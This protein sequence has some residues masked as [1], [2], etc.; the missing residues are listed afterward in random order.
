MHPRRW[1]N[2]KLIWIAASELTITIDYGLFWL[3]I[4]IYRGF[5]LFHISFLT[6]FMICS[7]SWGTCFKGTKS[8][9]LMGTSVRNGKKLFILF[10]KKYYFIRTL[11][12]SYYNNLFRRVNN[13]TV[14]ETP[15]LKNYFHSWRKY[16]QARRFIENQVFTISVLLPCFGVF[17][18]FKLMQLVCLVMQWCSLKCSR[19]KINIWSSRG[20]LLLP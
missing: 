5:F 20:L 13:G 6:G 17:S 15:M 9:S 10:G 14:F 7:I 8:M 18:L 1:H 4:Y 16:F 11:K 19:Q 3:Y 2:L 12:F